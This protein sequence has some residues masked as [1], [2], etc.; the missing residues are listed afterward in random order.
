M[1]PSRRAGHFTLALAIAAVGLVALGVILWSSAPAEF[2]WFSYGPVDEG[3]LSQLVFMPGRR[4]VALA[5]IV[6]GLMVLAGAVGFRLGLER[7]AL[8]RGE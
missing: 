5:A 1:S 6:S 4:W 7:G 3:F 8:P 2:G